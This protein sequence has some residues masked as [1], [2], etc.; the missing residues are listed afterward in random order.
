MPDSSAV[1]LS[2]VLDIFGAISSDASTSDGH[3]NSMSRFAN[4]G[5]DLPNATNFAGAALVQL[6]LR[7]AVPGL[8]THG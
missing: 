2:V 1:Q 6:E 5:D 7:G 3:G 4:C 8:Q